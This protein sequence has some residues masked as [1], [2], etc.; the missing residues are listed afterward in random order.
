MHRRERLTSRV[1]QAGCG[2]RRSRVQQRRQSGIPFLRQFILEVAAHL[3]LVCRV[4]HVVRGDD[5]LALAVMRDC[6]QASI[7]GALDSVRDANADWVLALRNAATTEE[8]DWIKAARPVLVREDWKTVE[9]AL[10][11]P[12]LEHRPRMG[13]SA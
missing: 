2:A 13:R 11:Q 3:D 10:R 7:G 4:I 6:T 12:S 8:Q 5:L 1:T 9:P